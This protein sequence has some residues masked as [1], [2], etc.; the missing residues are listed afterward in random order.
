MGVRV[1]AANL[2]NPKHSTRL[3]TTRGIAQQEKKTEERKLFHL[4]VGSCFLAWRPEV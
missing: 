3:N 4:L 1:D 2:C